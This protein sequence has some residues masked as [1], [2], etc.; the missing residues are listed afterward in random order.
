LLTFTELALCLLQ[1]ATYGRTGCSFLLLGLRSISK[2]LLPAAPGE[3]GKLRLSASMH[4]A[5]AVALQLACVLIIVFALPV[6]VRQ[7][8]AAED[9]VV[10][11][12]VLVMSRSF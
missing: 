12:G 1:Y 8:E 3:L 2:A 10:P 4:I 11:T 6:L 5:V 7:V 9:P